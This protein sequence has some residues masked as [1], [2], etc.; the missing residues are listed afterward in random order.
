MKINVEIPPKSGSHAAIAL[1][2]G[3][4]RG[5]KALCFS[6]L[7]AKIAFL[8]AL[9][10]ILATKNFDLILFP[11]DLLNAGR[12]MEYAEKFIEIIQRSGL[13][14]FWV[15]GNNDVG[16]AYSLLQAG[17]TSVENKKVKF[18]E[19]KIVGMGGV[20]DLWGHGIFPPEVSD[21]DIENSIFLS[22]IPVKNFVNYRKFDHTEVDKSVELKNRPKI[23]IC[24]HQH[25]YWG[26]A[27][28]GKTKIL[29]LPAGLLMMA[30]ILDTKT[31]K[32]EFINL[33]DYNK[34]DKVI[35]R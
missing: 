9:E 33:S 35:L 13:P 25:R 28:I 3:A 26:V 24:G 14:V 34:L 29:K 6:D 17:L 1:S 4:R 21:K 15:P 7:H 10:N 11:G 16:E 2:D 20:P 12:E 19:E 32:V 8:P 23:Q 30:A 18:G 22:H 5:M 27:Y 31:L